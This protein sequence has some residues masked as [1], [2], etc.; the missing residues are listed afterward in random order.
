MYYKSPLSTIVII[1]QYIGIEIISILS[2]IPAATSSKGSGVVTFILSAAEALNKAMKNLI[3]IVM[4]PEETA[5]NGI[6]DKIYF[7]ATAM[8]LVSSIIVM[9]NIAIGP[10]KPTRNSKKP[11]AVLAESAFAN[12]NDIAYKNGGLATM[13]KTMRTQT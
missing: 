2:Q 3:E 5:N 1:N 8:S 7:N 12:K 9:M 4:I 6:K 13:F 10:M 11:T